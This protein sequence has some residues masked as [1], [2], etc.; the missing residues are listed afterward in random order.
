[1]SRDEPLLL[2]M[3]VAAHEARSFAADLAKAQFFASRLHQNAVIRSLEVIGEA[4]SLVSNP[5]RAAHPEI[6][7]RQIIG[8]RNRLVHAYA[9]VSLDT[10]WDVIQARLP[11]LIASLTPLVP[12][13]QTDDT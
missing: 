9:R 10:I 6:P 7:W 2:D 12:P 3:L 4:A 8:M 5:C 1:M 13:D 11:E